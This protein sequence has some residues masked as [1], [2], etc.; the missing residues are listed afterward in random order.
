MSH[1]DMHDPNDDQRDDRGFDG[2]DENLAAPTGP[3]TSTDDPRLTAYALGELD[4]ADRT[5]VETFLAE[6]PDARAEVSEIQA[7]A[8]MLGTELAAVAAPGLTEAQRATIDAAVTSG[9]PPHAAGP[10]PILSFPAKSLAAAAAALMIL[11]VGA[12]YFTP[13]Q[14]FYAPADFADAGPPSSTRPSDFA[15]RDS[16]AG[17]SLQQL[18]YSRG[19]SGEAMESLRSMGYLD[20][21][22]GA[23]RDDR[24]P[25]IAGTVGGQGGGAGDDRIDID[26]ATRWSFRASRQDLAD[27]GDL[28]AKNGS[29]PVG[30]DGVVMRLGADV[31]AD[32]PFQYDMFGDQVASGDDPSADLLLDRSDVV[33]HEAFEMAAPEQMPVVEGGSAPIGVASGAGVAPGRAMTAG[34]RAN[35]AMPSGAPA[36]TSPA[37]AGSA[38]LELRFAGGEAERMAELG[39][40]ESAEAATRPVWPAP[41]FANGVLPIPLAP[42][43]GFEA[44]AP[45][46]LDALGYTEG[47]TDGD[48]LSSATR[49]YERD[50]RRPT[51]RNESYV[52]PPENAFTD[53][54]DEPLST[55]GVDVDTAS[56]SNVRRFL[57]NGQLPP[58]NAVRLEELVNAFDLGVSAD[59]VGDA[60]DERPLAVVV[61]AAGCP[62]APEHRLA[63]ITLQARPPSVERPPANLVFLVDVSGS[64]DSD[65]KLPLLKSSMRL[66]ISQLQT[67]DRVAIVTYSNNSRMAL[68]STSCEQKDVILAA[69]DALQPGGSTNGEAGLRQAYKTAN[70]HFIK[71]GVNRVFLA[72][73]GDFNVGASAESELKAIIT[74]SARTG[75]F[76]TVL[77]FGTGNLKDSKL[78]VMAD[79]G[80][81]QYAYIDTLAEGQRVLME[82]AGSTLEV[83]AKDVK[84]QVEFNPGKVAAYRLL[85]YENRKLAAQDF[86]DDRKDAGDIGAGHTVTALYEIVPTGVAWKPQVDA[87]RY[88]V[89]ADAVV[90]EE[91]EDDRVPVAV[92]SD[93]LLFVKMRWKTPEGNTSQL[94]ERSLMDGG[95]DFEQA[96]ANL[97]FGAAVVGFGMLLRDSAHAGDASFGRLAEI[98][99]GARGSDPGGHRAEFVRL[100]K[101][102]RGLTGR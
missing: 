85:G 46:V 24:R 16:E 90:E 21:T 34:R 60:F 15:A 40:G 68:P 83:V 2:G 82:Q 1:Q 87:L 45:P 88:Q 23:R 41:P 69:L 51:P 30:K 59:R 74:Q 80:N 33:F 3:L 57:M 64:M 7:T 101:L 6:H 39:Y 53:P 44:V 54:R 78:E 50:A 89:N 35:V 29:P 42:E 25:D 38:G 75:V 28:L 5:L 19:E 11:V 95:Q 67:Q 99:D 77:G 81:G 63:S 10:G 61:E 66:L 49:R 36:P 92:E 14:M 86:N 43:A 9:V 12:M 31:D 17:N 37:A 52:A 76:L 32:S 91:Q 97:R 20:A 70:E 27:G 48:D 84:L 65:N 96:S 56:Y 4:P 98:A 26:E 93:E 58:P 47:D 72:T 18:G 62:W 94:F 73:D 71:G 22:S 55:F 79:N 13:Q 102:A 8:A 100:V